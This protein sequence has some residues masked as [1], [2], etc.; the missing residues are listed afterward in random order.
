[1]SLWVF[2]K[3]TTITLYLLWR[4]RLQTRL[5]STSCW[6]LT[7]LVVTVTTNIKTLLKAALNC[8]FIIPYIIG[9]AKLL[10]NIRNKAAAIKIS[11]AWDRAPSGFSSQNNTQWS[12]CHEECTS[13]CETGLQESDI[14]FM[15]A[16][17]GLHS[18]FYAVG[19]QS[20]S[21]FFESLINFVQSWLR[22]L[23]RPW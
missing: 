8:G 13:D 6:T 14:T 21:A 23:L 1:M 7:Y 3:S 5:I 20:F 15:T 4:S 19:V 18:I 2:S 11:L 9:M 12:P 16:W 10:V 22:W 17:W